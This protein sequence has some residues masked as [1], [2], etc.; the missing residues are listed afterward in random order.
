MNSSP[1]CKKNV[2][3]KIS[4]FVFFVLYNFGV[5]NMSSIMQRF[6]HPKSFELPDNFD[7]RFDLN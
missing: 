4:V 1:T 7:Q 3:S 6:G 2:S 5:K